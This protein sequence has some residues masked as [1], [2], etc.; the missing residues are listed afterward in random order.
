[1]S[2]LAALV[3][4]VPL[5][6]APMAAAAQPYPDSVPLPDD[7]APEG[8][9]VGA[10]STFYVGS[11][12]DGDIYRGDLRSGDGEVF[13]DAPPGRQATGLK[14]DERHRRLVVAGGVTGQAF[15]YD[16]RAGAPLADVQLAP[17]GTGFINDVTVTRSAAYFTDSLNPVL[18]ELPI[19]PDGTVGMPDTITLT[20]PAATIAGDFNLN[21]IDATPNGDTLIVAHSALGELFTVDPAT[22]ASQEIEVTGDPLTPGT[23]DGI[24]LDGT[25]VWVVENFTERLVEVRLGPDLSTGEVTSVITDADVGGLFRVPTTVAE[26]GNRLALVNA[27]FDQGFP[28]PLGEGI[29][30]GTDYDVVLVDKS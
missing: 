14:V 13:I 15:V 11:L 12:V 19:A 29:P 7:F 1:M 27:R 26:H 21:G 10:G 6:V 22:G 3:L 18:Y 2:R 28:P 23:L 25:T 17:A 16:A 24:L 5:L 8:I 20:G 30:P 9:A 4:T